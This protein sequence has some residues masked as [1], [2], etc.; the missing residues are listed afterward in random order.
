MSFP[1]HDRS[2]C[3]A[4]PFVAQALVPVRFFLS[5]TPCRRRTLVRPAD[6]KVG[7]YTSP[8]RGMRLPY[9]AISEQVEL[10]GRSVSEV[11][12]GVSF[13]GC[14]GFQQAPRVNASWSLPPGADSIHRK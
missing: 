1:L 10:Y 7:H 4:Q 12:K 14:F 3:M 8:A 9:R 5:L 6:L 13:G 2:K 11:R